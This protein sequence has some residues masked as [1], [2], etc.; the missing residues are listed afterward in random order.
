M[1]DCYSRMKQS[2]ETK[3]EKIH[4]DEIRKTLKKLKKEQLL[5]RKQKRDRD[6]PGNDTD[7]EDSE[8]RGKTSKLPAKDKSKHQKQYQLSY[9]TPVG[10]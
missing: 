4:L 7:I 1:G 9:W 2:R 8:K 6:T 3:E 10:I 5:E